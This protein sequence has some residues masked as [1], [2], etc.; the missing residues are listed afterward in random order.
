MRVY[1]HAIRRVSSTK[2][3]GIYPS[4][5]IQ[6]PTEMRERLEGVFPSQISGFVIRKNDSHID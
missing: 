6:R 2:D 3:K 5:I 1:T 4:R